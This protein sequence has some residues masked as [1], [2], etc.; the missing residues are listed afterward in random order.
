VGFEGLIPIL[1]S[2]SNLRMNEGVR[3]MDWGWGGG[4][5]RGED[6]RSGVGDGMA[7]FYFDYGSRKRCLFLV[8][9]EES[10]VGI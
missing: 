4:L 1:P 3:C 6:R 5:L 10:A 2:H 7:W 8:L 9:E